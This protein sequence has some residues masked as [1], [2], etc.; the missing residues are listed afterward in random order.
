MAWGENM[1]F[2][3]TM[4]NNKD[5]TRL[6]KRGK[7][8]V[9]KACIF[10]YMPNNA[11]YNRIGL[12]TGKKVGNAVCRNRAR[13]IIRAAYRENEID[14]PIGLDIVIVARQYTSLAKSTEISDFFKKRVIVELKKSMNEKSVQKSRKG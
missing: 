12:T 9:S 10:Y 11:S 13:R 1:L 4:K 3:N 8:I 14:F 5:F 7:S 2:T 6:Y